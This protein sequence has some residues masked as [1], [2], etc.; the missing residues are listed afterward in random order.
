MVLYPEPGAKFAVWQKEAQMLMDL[1]EE[2][3]YRQRRSETQTLV[4]ICGVEMRIL[5]VC[6]CMCG[7]DG[8]QASMASGD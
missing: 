7:C 6:V 1:S 5:C 3:E 2:T 4:L 8:N